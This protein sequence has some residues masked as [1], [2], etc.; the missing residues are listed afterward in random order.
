MRNGVLERLPPGPAHLLGARPTRRGRRHRGGPRVVAGGPLH[1]AHALE[2]IDEPN[3]AR[4]GQTENL[5]ESVDPR[6][7]E[8][9]QEGRERGG[10]ALGGA[11]RARDRTPDPVADGHAQRAEQVRGLLGAPAAG[12]ALTRRSSQG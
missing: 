9:V 10:V 8:K 6:I 5:C 3:R 12:Q 1:E 11:G 2:A 4:G 7:D